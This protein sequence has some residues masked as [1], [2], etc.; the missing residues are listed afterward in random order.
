[1]GKKIILCFDGTCNDPEDAVQ[2]SKYLGLGG[3]KD[4]SITN[5]LKLHLLFGGDL[6]RPINPSEQMSFYYSGVGTYGGWFNKQK[7]KIFSPENEDVGKIIKKAARD[8]YNCYESADDEIYIFGFSRGAAIAR[9]FSSLLKDMFV[10]MGKGFEPKIKFLGVFDTVAAINKPNLFNSNKK[11]ASDVIFENHTIA[12]IIEEALHL[13]ALDE[14]RIAFQ[15]T[16]MNKEKKVREIWFPG[17][18]ADIG[19]GYHYDGLSDGALQFMLDWLESKQFGLSILE[20]TEIN[21]AKLSSDPEVVIDIQDVLI[22]PNHLGKNHQQEATTH[23]KEAFL[24]HR[25]LRVNIKDKISNEPPELHRSVIAKIHDDD[26]YRPEPLKITNREHPYTGELIPHK[27]YGIPDTFEALISHLSYARPKPKQLMVNEESALFTVYANQL[28]SPSN[29]LLTKGEKYRFIVDLDQKWF[30]AS[31]DC[32][33]K[34]WET[35]E[36]EFPFYKKWLINLAED[37][38]RCAE[39]DWFEIIA[40]VTKNDEDNVRL[41]HH[42]EVGDEYIP[43]ITGELYCYP[44]DLKSKY[45]NN[46][47]FIEIKVKRIA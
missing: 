31:I 15:P 22:Q 20:P 46:S 24:G 35:D 23:I 3:I 29:I 14:R 43:K 30:D 18:H 44:N 1:M 37:N 45:T 41:L 27:I 40:T 12:P 8:L 11:P 5:V 25:S 28:F 9:R 16:L 10:S 4:N 42:T 34:G 19:G 38:R 33:P 47:G 7:N 26:N 13:V 6:V 17:A 36:Q 2:S 39:A 32:G 21:Y